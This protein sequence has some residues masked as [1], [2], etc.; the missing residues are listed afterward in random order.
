MSGSSGRDIAHAYLA[1]YEQPDTGPALLAVL[2]TAMGSADASGVVDQMVLRQVAAEA[3]PERRLG[4][5]LVMGELVGLV[6][7]R[8]LARMPHLAALSVDELASLVGP[9]FDALLA[10]R[11]PVAGELS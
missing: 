5:E 3:P 4:V 11:P 6:V 7:A 10:T 9:H 1:A 2:R 8:H